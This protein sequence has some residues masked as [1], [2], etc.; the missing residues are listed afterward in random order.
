MLSVLLL[1][2]STTTG[3]R[4]DRHRFPSCHFSVFTSTRI[5]HVQY[6]LHLPGHF[7]LGQS[8]NQCDHDEILFPQRSI[9][10]ST[11]QFR[12]FA[13]RPAFLFE[14]LIESFI[15]Y[16]HEGSK[17]LLLCNNTREQLVG[18]TITPWFGEYDMMI[19]CITAFQRAEE[20]KG[21]EVKKNLNLKRYL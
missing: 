8:F 14:V 11:S 19:D 6:Y 3:H 21:D 7:V 1:V 15:G 4:G 12:T 9:E 16:S 10:I 2:L 5:S 13:R 18:P 20:K 17:Q